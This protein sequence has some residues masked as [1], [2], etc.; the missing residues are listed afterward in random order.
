MNLQSVMNSPGM[1]VAS[2]FMVIVVLIQSALFMREGYKAAEKLGMKRID[3]VKGMRA[4]MIT[5]IGPSLG[6]VVILLALLA[7][8]GGPTTWMRM[9]DIGAARTELAISALATKVAGVEMR[10][11]AFD[12]KA[13]SYAIWGMALNNMGWMLVALIFVKRMNSAIKKMNEKYNPAW[14]KLIMTG[15]AIGLFASLW[16]PA[17]LQG[18]GQFFAGIVAFIA[19]F[20]IGKYAG[21]YPRLQEPSLGIAMLIGM[22]AAAY[23]F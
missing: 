4:A 11:A 12:L 16:A 3:C 13:F 14:V 1:W 8:L 19:M 6:P 23:F 15:A 2:S 7:V 18:G 9:N 22:F 10:S 17:L 20:L 21:K 5:A